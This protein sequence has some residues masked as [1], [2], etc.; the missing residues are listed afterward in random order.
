MT[1]ISPTNTPLRFP[2]RGLLFPMALTLTLL[3]VVSRRSN[4][5]SLLST[6]RSGD[7]LW[8]VT[9][10][11][12]QLLFFT[13]QSLFYQSVCRV[14]GVVL[15]F[16]QLL[17]PVLSTNFVN[18]VAP[19]GSGSGIA[20]FAAELRTKGVSASRAVIINLLYYLLDYA[21]FLVTLM[22]GLTYLFLHHDLKSYEIAATLLLLGVIAIVVLAALFTFAHEQ[23]LKRLLT[24][25]GKLFNFASRIIR[26]PP[27]LRDEHVAG[28]AA[29]ILAATQTMLASRAHILRPILHGFMIEILDICLLTCLFMAFHTPTHLGVII[30][31]YG[32]AVLFMIVSITPQGLG[33]VETVMTVVFTS[34][35]I[36][37]HVAAVV[38]LTY[39]G[40]TFWLPFLFGFL[41][42]RHLDFLKS[43]AVLRSR[44]SE[45]D[46][47]A[48]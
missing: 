35:G 21:A 32:I 24:H 38:T 9:G 36:P 20:L 7:P 39:R 42:L 2:W 16:R 18:I 15:P 37:L 47:H 28:I 6:F 4:A 43:S 26:R 34:L 19:L 22:F 31:G 17:P 27:M 14:F 10:F 12:V 46:G 8:L 1:G 41:S 30:T 11:F 25:L 5:A 29:D 48:E 44:P 33:V 40:M 23:R 3:V 13:N 45:G